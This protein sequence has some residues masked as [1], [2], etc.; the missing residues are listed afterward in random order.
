MSHE[1]NTYVQDLRKKHYAVFG[2]HEH[3]A[4]KLCLWLKKSLRNDGHCYKQ[5]FYGI[6]SHRCLQMTPN[7]YCQQRCV[8][9]WRAWEFSPSSHTPAQ[10]DEP[11]DI[12]DA[13]IAAQRKLI[14]GFP[15]FERTNMKKFKEAQDP[16]QVAISLTGEPTAYPKISELVEGYDRRGFTTFLV[17]NGLLPDT[18]AEMTLPTQLYVSLDAPNREM[19]QRID[20]P[21]EK[22]AWEKLNQTLGLLPSLDTRKVIRITAIKGLNMTNAP[23]YT[24][25]IKKA[26]PDFVEVKAYMLIGQSRERLKL[27]NMPRHHEVVDFAKQ[28][29]SEL[30]YKWGGEKQESR[31]VLLTSGNKKSMI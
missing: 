16:N 10:W 23:E 8:F 12:I 22:D 4:A 19:H 24:Q 9:C 29:N 17:T 7:I 13:S 18:L 5:E 15:G 31:V 6:Q 25:L 30:G 28:L 2:K 20:A 11:D 14:S 1:N 3:S 26:D 21:L 27:E